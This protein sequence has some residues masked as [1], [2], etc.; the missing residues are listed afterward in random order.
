MKTA[1]VTGATAG[2]GLAIAEAF[3]ALGWRVAIGA[4]RAERLDGAVAAVERAGGRGFG[5]VL[6]VT[7]A[8]SVDAFVTAPRRRSVPIDVLVNNAGVVR[9]RAAARALSPEPIRST[10]ETNLL[11]RAVHVAPRAR[12]AAAG[13]APRGHRVHLLARRRGAVAA[14]GALRGRQGGRREPPLRR[15]ASSSP[16]P[17]SARWSCAWAT[18]P[19]SSRPRWSARAV[20]RTSATGAK[21][22]LVEG[23]LLQAAHVAAAVVA[24][25]TAPRGVQLETIVVNPEPPLAKPEDDMK[26]GV[27]L[28]MQNYGDWERYEA[29]ERGEAHGPARIP[30][31]KIYEEDL[32]IGRLVEPLGFDSLWSVEHHFTPYTMVTDVLQLLTYFAGCHRAHR[33]RHDGDRAAVARPDPRRR[34]HRGA[35]HDARRPAPPHRLRSR[36]RP[37]RVRRRCA[38]RWRSR[39]SASSSR[40]TSCAPRS[41]NEW[42]SLQGR[43]PRDPAHHAAPAAALARAS[44]SRCTAHGAARRRSRS[45]PPPASRRCSSRRPR[46]RTTRSR[47]RASPTLRG[48][49]GFAPAHP[50]VVCWVYCAETEEKAW[51]GARKYIPAYANSARAPLRARERSLPRRRRATSTTPRCRRC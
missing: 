1:L 51:E 18:P 45:P 6:D 14:P 35:R 19:P 3:G 15:C 46:G 30:D 5:H 27:S 13:A 12:F 40:S 2:I 49:A 28:F 4:R 41:R 10:V 31:W 24:A 50:T 8:A 17:A 47:W 42:F 37:A 36:S 39:A 22:G 34:R 43:V 29:Q 11:G 21:L 16:A 33:A 26:V 7:D 48:E 44:P 23:G 38:S 32:H 20:R 9:A 25:V